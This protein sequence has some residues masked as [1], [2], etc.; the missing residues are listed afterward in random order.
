LFEM[1][2]AEWWAVKNL[3]SPFL[4]RKYAECYIS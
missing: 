1:G 3:M 4:D 2:V